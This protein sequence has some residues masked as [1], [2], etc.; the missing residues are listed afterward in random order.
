LDDFFPL[1]KKNELWG[2]LG[3]TKHGG[4][5]ASGRR[6]IFFFI[7][8]ILSRVFYSAA[9]KTNY[10]PCAR[11]PDS[12]GGA[13]FLV[14]GQCVKLAQESKLCFHSLGGSHAMKHCSLSLGPEVGPRA[15][16]MQ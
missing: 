7:L 1:K 12:P 15:G 11:A 10:D 2:I 5:Q 8:Y 6:V 3:P 16:L 13:F 14:C 9:R 4:N